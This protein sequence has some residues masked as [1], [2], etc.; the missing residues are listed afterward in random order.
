MA[1]SAV[2]HGFIV[3]EVL[4]IGEKPDARFSQVGDIAVDGEGFIYA[5]DRYRYR[6]RKFSPGGELVAEFGSAK[7]KLAGFESG[8]GFIAVG[9]SLVTVSDLTTA[10]VL[11]LTKSLTVS[12]DLNTPGPAA[13]LAPWPGNKFLCAV[14]PLDGGGGQIL[15]LYDTAHSVRYFPLIRMPDDLPLRMVNVRIDRRGRII[16]AYE[17]RNTVMIFD[18]LAGLISTFRIPGMPDDVAVDTIDRSSLGVVPRGDLIKSLAVYQDSLIFVL[19][20]EYAE[21]PFRD[22]SVVDYRGRLLEI[23]T[24]PRE[25]G[26]IYIDTK[27]FLYTREERRTLIR[28]YVVESLKR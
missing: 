5:S 23:F 27:G 7:G 16:A 2:T 14:L 4:T 21:H 3:R 18:S 8:P 10:R 22:V 17:F 9:E 25:T 6:L 24:L 15:G 12:Y 11:G 13:S 1:Q 28:K 26:L 20:A 19:G